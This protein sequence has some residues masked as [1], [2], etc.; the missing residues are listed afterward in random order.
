[1]STGSH[2]EIERKYL[3]RMPDVEALRALPG[4]QEWDITQIYLTDGEGG[5]TRR[6]RRVI[7][8]G[9]TR[10]YRTFKRRLTDLSSAEDEGEITR[11]VF[12]RLCLERDRGRV[13]ILKTRFRVPY[14]G[15]VLEY[16]VYPFWSDRAILE[17]ELES[18]DETADIPPEVKVIRDVTGEKAYKNRQLA[19]RV[20]MEALDD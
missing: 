17:I 15:H 8:A 19:K 18:E 12:D 5:Q 9:Q 14:R 20:P 16:D 10:Y 4:C 11:E 6:V 1:M 13:P 7:E 3:I 2:C